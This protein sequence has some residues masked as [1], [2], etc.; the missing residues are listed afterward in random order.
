VV[1]DGQSAVLSCA[2]ILALAGA[3]WLVSVMRRDAS[4]VDVLWG[5]FFILGTLGYARH[6][7]M[8]GRAVLTLALVALWAGRLSGYLLWRN[9]GAPEDRRYRAMRER[10]EPGFAWKSAYLVFGLQAVLAWILSTPLWVAVASPAP[11]S[12]LDAVGALVWLAGFVIETVADGQ[13]A[14][15][16]RSAAT[17]AVLDR[18]LWRYTRHPN[19]FGEATLW[20][21][22]YL[23]AVAAGGAWTVFA[24][25]LMTFLLLRVSGV[26]LLEADIRDRRPDYRRYVECTNA[27]LPGPRKSAP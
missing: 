10:H 12:G 26:T 25:A 21:G 14:G 5:L 19:Y 7:P 13:L 1:L 11:L 27:F 18:G 16:R 8:S 3:G 20:W 2:V 9:W 6:F 24:P 23:I 22:Y 15:F 17:S 4:V